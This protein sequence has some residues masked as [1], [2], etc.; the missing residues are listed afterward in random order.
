MS[1]NGVRAK[2]AKHRQGMLP[3]RCDAC[4]ITL[5]DEVEGN[6]LGNVFVVVYDEDFLLVCH[7]ILL[8]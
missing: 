2:L 6:E 3:V 4:L 8:T 5:F 1:S 7:L